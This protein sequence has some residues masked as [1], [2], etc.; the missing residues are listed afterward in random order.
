MAN[1]PFFVPFTFNMGEVFMTD[2]A[3]TEQEVAEAE[4]LI[5]L[6]RKACKEES[7]VEKYAKDAEEA[8]LVCWGKAKPAILGFTKEFSSMADCLEPAQSEFKELTKVVDRQTANGSPLPSWFS[9]RFDTAMGK[10]VTVLEK[11]K[12]TKELSR[13]MQSG[14]RLSPMAVDDSVEFLRNILGLLDSVTE[15]WESTQADVRKLLG[16]ISLR[17]TS[18]DAQKA[19]QTWAQRSEARV[20]YLRQKRVLLGFPTQRTVVLPTPVAVN[21]VVESLRRK[22]TKNANGSNGC[23]GT[24]GSNGSHMVLKENPEVEKP[25]LVFLVNYQGTVLS[26][27]DVLL[28][29]NGDNLANKLSEHC[30]WPVEIKATMRKLRRIFNVHPKERGDQDTFR[31]LGS[32]WYKVRFGKK[33]RMLARIEDEPKIVS[34]IAGHRTKVYVGIG[35]NKNES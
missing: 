16:D 11:T 9:Q 25:W 3:L 1:L 34:L 20:A 7:V 26:S 23:N 35:R 29:A 27:F 21:P 6:W 12:M 17:G 14:I 2:S 10:V 24:N 15:A 28:S 13:L 19:L 30:N 5:A 22:K 18:F 8:L 32:I 31:H 33:W 4:S